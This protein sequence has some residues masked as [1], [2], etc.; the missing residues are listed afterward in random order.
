[1]TKEKKESLTKYAQ[2]LKNKLTSPVPTKHV[3]NP[4]TYKQFLTRE[5][6]IVTVALNKEKLEAVAGK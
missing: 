3:N 4:H 6:E 1:M 2:E 5:L